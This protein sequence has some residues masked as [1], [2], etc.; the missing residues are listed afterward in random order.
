MPFTIVRQDITKMQVDAIVNATNTDLAMGG[1][2][3]GAIFKAAGAAKL[4]AACDKVSPIKTGGAAITP[5]FDLTAKY[6]IHAAG[7]VYRHWNA[8]RNEQL[9]RSAYMESL[10][11]AYDHQCQSIAFPLISA[12][13]YGYPLKQALEIAVSSMQAFLTEHEMQIYLTVLEEKLIPLA[14]SFLRRKGEEV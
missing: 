5:G 12:G 6:V 1:G 10:K 13:I 4:Q 14:E 3:C 8:E 7:P 9:L 11:L 2:V